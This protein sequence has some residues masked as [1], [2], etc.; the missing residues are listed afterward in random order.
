MNEK[1]IEGHKQYNESK[2]CVVICAQF[3]SPLPFICVVAE[4]TFQMT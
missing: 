3:F 1:K 2:N 4:R